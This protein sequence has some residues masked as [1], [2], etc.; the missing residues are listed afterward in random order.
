MPA[1]RRSL[2]HIPALDSPQVSKSTRGKQSPEPRK[3]AVC[4]A[5][6][7]SLHELKVLDSPIEDVKMEV[8]AKGRCEICVE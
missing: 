4:R 3:V 1:R 8:E 5:I 2:S 7:Y 6:L